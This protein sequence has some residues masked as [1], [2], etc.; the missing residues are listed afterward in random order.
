MKFSLKELRAR[1][2]WTQVEAAE[3]IGVSSV[4]YNTWEQLNEK[5]VE[6][7]AKAYGVE[8]DEICVPRKLN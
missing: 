2:C 1:K 4:V 6:K 7:M 3:H 8:P 5:D